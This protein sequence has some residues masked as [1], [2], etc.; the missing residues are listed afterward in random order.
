[1]LPVDDGIRRLAQ[2]IVRTARHGSLA[3]LEPATGWPL[4]TRVGCSA[5]I[6]GAPL[7]IA[8]A[9]SAHTQALAGN[10][11]CSLLLGESGRG[12]PLAHPRMTV[13]GTA[14]QLNPGPGRDRARRRYLAR[15][16]KARLYA[17]FPDFSFW[18][19]HVAR[20]HLN[21]GF[22]RAHVLSAFDVLLD[23]D[24]T[25][26]LAPAEDRALQ[27]M[28]RDHADAVAMYGSVLCN[29]PAGQWVI[30]GIDSEGL[31]LMLGD[32][33]RRLWFDHPVQSV[34]EL[35]S[36]LVELADE[37]RRRARDT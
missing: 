20:A 6:D 10:P 2:T 12:D 22:G 7:F 26:A 32:D 13:I 1:M 29:G 19:L 8:S 16:P 33:V 31:D 11:R 34:D 18:R 14:R 28:N 4:A 21:A 23:P 15:H 25:M 9:L 35:R 24:Q 36:T 37:A 30:I 3:T 17:D 27:H 5:D